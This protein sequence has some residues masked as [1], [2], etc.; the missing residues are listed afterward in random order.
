MFLGMGGMPAEVD[1]FYGMLDINQ[2]QYCTLEGASN[3]LYVNQL[4]GVPRATKA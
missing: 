1:C 2:R 4:V 3:K